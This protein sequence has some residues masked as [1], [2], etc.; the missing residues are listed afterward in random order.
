[1]GVTYQDVLPR[2]EAQARK[3]RKEREE[4]AKI[5]QGVGQ[6]MAELLTDPRWA[7]YANHLQAVLESDRKRLNALR[8]KLSG[9]A[10]LNEVENGQARVDA[11]YAKGHGDGLEW[12]MRLAKELVE[13]GEAAKE[14][15]TIGGN[16]GA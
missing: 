9:L 11:A 5:A 12:A 7:I 16:E 10:F 2:L 15:L 6:T 1:M 3:R 13:Q 8:D 14:T 4:Q